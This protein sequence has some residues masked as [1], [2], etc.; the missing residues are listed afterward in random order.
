M[1]DNQLSIC[2][3][4]KGNMEYLS[5]CVKN[6]LK[7]SLEVFYIDL[8]SDNQNKDK[9]RKLGV[10][11]VDL[12]SLTT[13]LTSE[14]VLL[15]IKSEE[16]PVV[17]SPE[18]FKKE[19]ENKQAQGYGIYT[20][21]L[22]IRPL[23]EDYQWVIKLEQFK[24]IGDSAYV[25]TIEPRLLRRSLAKEGLKYLAAG[26]ADELSWV[27]GNIAKGIVLE[28]A[29]DEKPDNEE[30][31]RDHDIRC[32]KGELTCDIT[33]EDDM[34]ELSEMYTGFRI[35]HKGQLAGF[36]E[37]ASRG[38]GNFKLFI[39]MLEFLC[40]EGY[41]TEAKD[42]FEAWIE[43]RPD[44]KKDYNAQL[45]GGMIYANRLEIDKAIEWFA[46][47]TKTSESALACANI[48]K[49]YLIKGDKEKAIEHLEI[50]RDIE[51]DNCKR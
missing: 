26:N 6:A 47:I 27:C 50:S 34:V 40:K 12:N 30:K 9:A 23:I 43:N 51:G 16:R 48:G 28:P 11:I 4:G 8:E 35:L 3:L 7:I 5:G 29:T 33:P 2:I 17:S 24:N 45:M 36:M 41:F 49:L 21:N 14:W 10:R 31:T 19:L 1:I 25:S 46:K 22:K 18:K 37:G 38:F 20:K 13:A 42:L 32:L 44:D 15:F 39:P